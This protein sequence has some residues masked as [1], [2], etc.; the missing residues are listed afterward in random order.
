MNEVWKSLKGVVENGDFYEVSNYGNVRSIDRMVTNAR[1]TY[2]QSSVV[3]KQTK[4]RGYLEVGLN[5]N[6]TGKIYG[7]HRLVALA[8]I[9][10]PNN[11]PQVNHIDGNKI[12]NHADN[13]E[14]ATRSEN[15]QHAYDNGLASGPK[16]EKNGS[17]KLT[18]RQVKIIKQ[19]LRGN[20]LTHGEIGELVG[21]K[22]NR[23][24]AINRG[25]SWTHVR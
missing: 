17:A 18:E 16:G 4:R 25:E 9:P 15:V 14:W 7:V 11:K 24:S 2:L 23:I 22:H 20:K 3:L 8:F 21:V 6:A 13:L 1:G 12:N 10:N 5:K 19:L